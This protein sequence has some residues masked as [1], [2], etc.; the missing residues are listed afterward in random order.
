MTSAVQAMDSGHS[1][2]APRL[3]GIHFCMLEARA[4]H[5]RGERGMPAFLCALESSD[6][7]ARSLGHSWACNRKARE[8]ECS[9]DGPC[10]FSCPLQSSSDEA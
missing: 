2:H 8:A 6:D 7:Q 4:Q 1:L 3:Q 9:A 5:C 10:L